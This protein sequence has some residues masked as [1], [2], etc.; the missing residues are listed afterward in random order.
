MKP[1]FEEHDSERFADFN[2]KTCHGDNAQEVEFQMPNGLAPLDPTQLAAMFESDQPMAKFMT[3]TVWP[4]MSELL[5]KPRF[6]PQTG[7]GFSCL[8]CHAT[9][10]K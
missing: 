3:G 10:V 9:K 7:Q 6:D 8:N 4:K 5:G 1:L 2:C